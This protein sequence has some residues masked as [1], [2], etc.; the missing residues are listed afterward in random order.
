MSSAQFYI[1]R[2]AAEALDF[3]AV[4]RL[5]QAIGLERTTIEASTVSVPVGKTRITCSIEMT[6]LLIEDLRMLSGVASEKSNTELLAACSA[7]VA[8][9]IQGIDEA[10]ARDALESPAAHTKPAPN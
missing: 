5:A 2:R 6:A 10:R 7:A 3:L 1:P 8:A 4:R 9:A